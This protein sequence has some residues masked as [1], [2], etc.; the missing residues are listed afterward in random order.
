MLY[1][2]K[3]SK[4][5]AKISSIRQIDATET[6]L[7]Q[8]KKTSHWHVFFAETFQKSYL[9]IVSPEAIITL[10]VIIA[11]AVLFI[12]ELVTVDIIALG[13]VASLVI[14]GVIDIQAGLS[15]FSNTATITVLAMFV[16]SHALIRTRALDTIKPVFVKIIQRSYSSSIALLSVIVGGISAFINNT[17]VVATL[18]PVLNEATNDTGRSPSRYLIPLSYVAIM[19]GACTLVGTSTNL[20]VAGIA[21]DQGATP[22]K[23]FTLAPLG[24]VMAGVG[25]LFLILFGKR[26]LPDYK[27]QQEQFDAS[28]QFIKNYLAELLVIRN[29]EPEEATIKQIA[30]D[31]EI[32]RINRSHVTDNQ[33]DTSTELKVGDSILVRG[34]I[35]KIN[36]LLST[37]LMSSAGGPDETTFP[38]DE[39]TLIEVVLLPNSDIIGK[40]LRDVDFLKRFQSRILAI[41]QRGTEWF[42]DLEKVKLKAGDVLLVQTNNNGYKVFMEAQN[43]KS[44]PF[45]TTR[46]LPVRKVNKTKL[47]TALG[48]ISTVILLASLG[49]ANIAT[50]GICGIIALNISGVIKMQEAYRAIDWQV[51]FMLAGGLSLEK[52]MTS[53]G[54]SDYLASF[55][56]Q[57]IGQQLGP[58]AVIST[59]YLTTSFLTEIMSNNAA[60]ALLAPIGISIAGSLD[61]SPLPFLVAVAFAGS[62]SF[63]TPVGYQTNTMV[64][65]AGNYKFSDFTRIGIPLNLIFWILA[66]CL[67]PILYPL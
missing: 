44:S 43:D 61:A 7:I 33:P 55:L 64:F 16:L 66:T 40:R 31:L 11:A 14:S 24:L 56:L 30:G 3:R 20:L 65:S 32:I 57:D 51:I 13:I 9:K 15:G 58:I 50:L 62:A 12:T 60:A 6:K 59:L 23:M 25:T 54:L 38:E 42:K 52:A 18:I 10:I 49:V 48:V 36:E 22:I 28:S 53:S 5:L 29:P 1:F 34:D 46:Q 2:L 4:I 47:Y 26:L 35:T 19:G 21:E 67:I 37:G 41:R 27:S 17:P 45:V 39:T 63:A 8:P